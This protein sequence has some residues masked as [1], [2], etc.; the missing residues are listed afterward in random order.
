MVLGLLSFGCS[1]QATGPNRVLF[2]YLGDPVPPPANMHEA[3]TKQ[4]LTSAVQDAAQ[5]ANITLP[6][7]EVD[8]S[9]FPF[10][11]GMVCANRSDMEKW[12]EQIRRMTTY[13]YSG[14]VGGDT[15]MVMNLVPS[16]AFPRAAIERIQHRLTLRQAVFYDR[17]NE[18]H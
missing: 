4:G 6:K 5:A 16:S 2:D 1:K 18:T 9:E 7:V 11:V 3:Y 15:R 10:L 14:G 13:N 12:K 17:M 8:D